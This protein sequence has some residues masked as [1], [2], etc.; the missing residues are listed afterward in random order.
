M[1]FG[2]QK[3]R[4]L[5]FC[6]EKKHF[7]INKYGILQWYPR[8]KLHYYCVWKISFMQHLENRESTAFSHFGDI[9]DTHLSTFWEDQIT[10]THV[11]S[12]RNEYTIGVFIILIL[13]QNDISRE[14]NTTFVT[15]FR[16][17]NVKYVNMW[18]TVLVSD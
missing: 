12:N 16:L 10:Q 5:C 18:H 2:I 17:K 3:S 6:C 11:F 1:C 8:F 4:F 14:K 9:R 15:I 13:I 7:S